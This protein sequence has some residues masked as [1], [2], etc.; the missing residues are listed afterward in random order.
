MAGD[1]REVGRAWHAIGKSQT[2]NADKFASYN[3]ALDAANESPAD[4]IAVKII[5]SIGQIQDTKEKEIEWYAKGIP[6]GERLA[7]KKS[8]S[9]LYGRIGN[10]YT[11]NGDYTT[12]RE[13][14]ARSLDIKLKM[15][16]LDGIAITANNLG[17]IS[18][19]QGDINGA[20]DNFQKALDMSEPGDKD[21]LGINLYNLGNAYY[22]MGD[23]PTAMA[24]YTKSLRTF[25]EI[26]ANGGIEG[27]S[28]NIANLYNSQ[29]NFEQARVYLDRAS[30]IHDKTGQVIPAYALGSFADSY[31]GEGNYPKAIDYYEKLLA[32]KEQANNKDSTAQTLVELAYS[33]LLVPDATKAAKYFE[34][35][36]K[37]SESSG[38]HVWI[39]FALLGKAKT[40]LIQNEYR[41]AMRDAGLAKSHFE[42]LRGSQENWELYSVLGQAHRGIGQTAEARINFD[43]A[44]NIIE[45]RRGRV[46]GGSSE[47]QRFFGD[48]LVPYHL[49]AELLISHGSISEAFKYIELAKA[50]TLVETIGRGKVAIDVSMT[51]D[52]RAREQAFRNE[53]VSLV[54]QVDKEN[55][56]AKPDPVSL[57]NLEAL[58]VKKRLASDDFQVQLF[59][60]H[61]ELRIQRGEMTPTSVGETVSLFPDDKTAMVEYVVAE[62]N[63]FV[64]VITKDNSKASLN[65]YPVDVNDKDFAKRIE[66]YRSMLAR[67]DLDLQKASRELY[68]LLLKPASAL[69]EGKTNII[70][71]PDGPLWGLPFQA[72]MD[73]KGKYLIEKAAVSYAPS[74]TALREMRKKAATRRPS[75]DAELI[76]FGNP[77]V[78][79]ETKQRVQRVFM[80]EK[81][82]PLPEAERLVKELGKMYGPTRSKIF[83]GDAAR[84]ETAKME[85]PKYRIVQFATHGILNNVSP[86]Y[87]HLVMSQDAKNPNED[88]LLEAWEL[89]DLDLKADMVILTACETAR[90]KISNG[91]GMIGMTWASFI[92][93]APTTVASQWKVESS[94]TTELMLEFH[95]QM[96]KKKR[97]S[98]AEA[99]RRA[100]LKLLKN[101]QYRH[102]SYWAG[103]VLI[104]DGS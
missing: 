82:E 80:N 15:N 13:Y 6:H 78:G 62:D 88:G 77:I 95:R 39:S 100:S 10:A 96:L 98:K 36:L 67:G 97:V 73:E 20:L 47:R 34:R 94:S 22:E 81:L 19:I 104:G 5:I 18:Q 43:K 12:A 90:G 55:K 51:P 63:T 61:P 57:A 48:K 2:G 29:G 27:V 40:H 50:R 1:K 44:I 54:S 79:S 35:A 83:T 99:L 8:L 102:P 21:V 9:G 60:S 32:I 56:K 30:K 101:P 33:Y 49:I 71:V 89:K 45:D 53:L 91:E 72:L 93:G 24:L 14:H 85:S 92:A 52:E 42:Q 26:G 23:Y 66:A 4:D 11:Q 65:A 75:Q 84:E 7:D 25:E 74:L 87:S 46:A 17:I 59:S 16:D 38:N 31:K 64:F 76:A 69:L 41:S 68:D 3:K 86:M 58:I 103:F 37:L 70:I 28:T